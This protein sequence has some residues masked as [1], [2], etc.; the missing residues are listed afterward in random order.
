MNAILAAIILNSARLCG[1][2]FTE[3]LASQADIYD[4]QFADD[5]AASCRA[6]AIDPYLDGKKLG[7]KAKLEI[8]QLITTTLSIEA[9]AARVKAAARKNHHPRAG[10][11]PLWPSN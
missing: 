6:I 5:Y 9:T 1:D 7:A 11:E 10:A 3:S 4:Q 2:S 8:E